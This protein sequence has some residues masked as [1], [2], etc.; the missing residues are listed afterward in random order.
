[1]RGKKIT[2]RFV[3]A[4]QMNIPEMPTRIETVALSELLPYARNSRTH[5]EAQVKKIIASIQVFGFTN[6][7]LTAADGEIIAGHGRVLAARKMGLQAVPVIRLPHLTEAQRRAYVIADNRIALDAGWD[8]ELLRLE[9]GEIGDEIDLTV[10]GFSV[11]E[12]SQL[13][14][15]ETSDGASKEE[16]GEPSSRKQMVCCPRCTNTFDARK[17]KAGT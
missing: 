11:D 9:I 16:K 1:V 15:P 2:L 14:L 17:H 10:T 13:V 3:G 7:V 4:R 8:Q 6:P 12:L 5:S